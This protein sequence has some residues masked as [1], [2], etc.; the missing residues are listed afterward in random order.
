ML[1]RLLPKFD[2]I[3]LTE[4][5]S[6]PRVMKATEL[7]AIA[8][9]LSHAKKL[10]DSLPLPRGEGRGEG[11]C[12]DLRPPTPS[13]FPSGNGCDTAI[14]TAP[15]PTAAW[16]LARNLATPDD[17]ICITGS[18]FLAAEMRHL[19]ERLST[20]ELVDRD[21]SQ[22]MFGPLSPCGRGLG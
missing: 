5:L 18:F 1:A 13:D 12:S 19:I 2:H 16:Q 6:N 7:E 4:Y 15:N 14:Q 21:A 20:G 17:L 3:V 9:E 11:A 10:H 22:R 8:A